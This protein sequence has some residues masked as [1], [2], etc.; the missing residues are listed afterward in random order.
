MTI[1]ALTPILIAMI[2]HETNRAYCQALG[3]DSQ[4]PWEL[5]E[6]WQIESAINGVQFHLDNPTAGDAASHEN[7]LKEKYDTGWQYREVKDPERKLHPCMVPFKDLPLDQQIKDKLFRQTVH[8]LLPLLPQSG[9]SGSPYSDH[10]AAPLR[11]ELYHGYPLENNFT[12]HPPQ[13]NQQERYV[14][15]R[16]GGKAMAKLI[17]DLCPQS[18]ERSTAL[19]QLELSNMMANAAIARNE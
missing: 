13:G 4:P 12:Y 9:V 10:P 11:T 18:R 5:A 6:K 19:T 17:L 3:D 15:L 8:A 14:A 2:C 7:W 16:D 1:K